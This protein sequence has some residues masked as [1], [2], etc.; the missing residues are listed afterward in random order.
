MST[1]GN[2]VVSVKTLPFAGTKAELKA[3]GLDE[4]KLIH[5]DEWIVKVKAYFEQIG[6]TDV[7]EGRTAEP[8][9]NPVLA[10]HT[11]HNE[12]LM[13]LEGTTRNFL[14]QSCEG[15]P[16]QLIKGQKKA[17]AMWKKLKNKYEPKNITSLM[18]LEGDFHK[19]KME[20]NYEDPLVWLSR[21]ELIKS[22]IEEHPDGDEVK[23]SK[24]I[25]HIMTTLPKNLYETEIKNIQKGELKD[26]DDIPMALRD[27]YNDYDVALTAND[28]TKKGYKK[29]KG[30][31]HHCGKQ[32]HKK[33]ECRQLQNKNNGEQRAGNGGNEN[34]GGFKGTCFV[35][36]KKGHR[37]IECRQQKGGND[38]DN[39]EG[40]HTDEHSESHFVGYVET[41]YCMECKE[42]PK[43]RESNEYDKLDSF[44]DS[45]GGE[46]AN[47]LDESESVEQKTKAS[48]DDVPEWADYEF[49]GE[50]DF[51][52]EETEEMINSKYKEED[53]VA[54]S[55]VSIG[56]T[57]NN[58]HVREEDNNGWTY[59]LLDA[60]LTTHIDLSSEGMIDMMRMEKGED[61]VRVGNKK[62]VDAV[63]RGTRRLVTEE[64]LTFDLENTEVIPAFAKKII[65][66]TKL[67]EKGNRIVMDG[68]D[69]YIENGRGQ[70][71]KLIRRPDGMIGSGQEANNIEQ[72]GKKKVKFADKLI[73][74][75]PSKRA[76]SVDES[77][78]LKTVL[79]KTTKYKTKTVS[80]DVLHTLWGHAS[81]KYVKATAG[82]FGIKI[83]GKLSPCFGCAQAKARQK[84]T[85]K[86]PIT[87]ATKPGERMFLDLSGPFEKSIAGSKYWLKMVDEFLIKV[88]IDT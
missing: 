48:D 9:D 32:G 59:W 33:S 20:N 50:F 17:D 29:F 51:K 16:L 37:A 40:Y 83:S 61:Q 38:R 74:T 36:G 85:A 4:K 55:L 42:E 49:T 64:K 28:G 62:F 78:E 66:G 70:R 44:F 56:E 6:V 82:K 31:C 53:S 11:E 26:Y 1:D 25:A 22:Q 24:M 58:L 72:G 21:L 60:G 43:T 34:N 27:Q 68:K 7:V 67:N 35:C 15:V 84:N 65:S 57:D 39:D 75:H 13:K 14:M 63:A 81:E 5:P 73:E 69:S 76:K 8:Y 88:S 47:G 12:K 23:D 10:E 18:K 79:K 45:F 54:V 2:K 3:R 19:C 71:V 30:S 77:G 86:L 52:N 41:G 87:P 80:M 46:E